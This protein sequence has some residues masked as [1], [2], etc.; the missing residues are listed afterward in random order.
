MTSIT[1]PWSVIYKA[2]AD[3]N[4][5]A[6]TQTT[7]K[8]RDG[9]LTTNLQET[10]Q[11]M[12]QILTPENNKA[13]D[14]EMLKNTR[15]LAQEDIDTNDDKEFT[16]HEVRNVVMSMGKNKAP[17]EEGKPSEVFKSVVESL[18]K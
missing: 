6:A 2:Q 11:H 13:V 15:V 17:G 16:V 18:P 5:R 4:K 1:N 12:L 8:Q 7:V 9:T 10:I 14:P 3:R